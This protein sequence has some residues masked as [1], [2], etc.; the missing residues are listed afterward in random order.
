M[1][2]DDAVLS[3][4]MEE[5]SAGY[6]V[7]C[8]LLELMRDSEALR[9]VP[10]P[11]RLSFALNEPD[12]ELIRRVLCD[13]ALFVLQPD[14]TV[15]SPFL[16]ASMAAYTEQR[17]AAREAGKRG[18]QKRW[19]KKTTD[20]DSQ[21]SEEVPPTS[22]E[23]APNTPPHIGSIANTNIPT[24]SI[25]T[26]EEKSTKP[27]KLLSLNWQDWTG[28]RLVTLCKESKEEVPED[29]VIALKRQKNPEHNR[30]F[31]AECCRNLHLS[32]PVCNFILAYTND[33]LVG[34]SELKKFIRLYKYI[35]EGDFRPTHPNEYVISRLLGSDTI[36]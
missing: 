27:S 5:G 32:M 7:Y 33:A 14:G 11:V 13:Y 25:V 15:S 34:S 17:N 4:R 28:E 24:Q 23:I 18:A 19:G 9:L 6:G 12:S 20:N 36:A 26:T 2:N 21:P 22:S 35:T 3:M 30:G 31:V 16:D 8:M 10:N 29:L 1:R